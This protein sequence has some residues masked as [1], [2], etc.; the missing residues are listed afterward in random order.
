MWQSDSEIFAIAIIVG[1]VIGLLVGVS[2]GVKLHRSDVYSRCVTENKT[3]I[4]EEV[5]KLCTERSK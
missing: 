4:Y 1:F 3:M 5:H 2:V